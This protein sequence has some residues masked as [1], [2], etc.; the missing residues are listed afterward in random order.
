MDSPMPRARTYT[1]HI[2]MAPANTKAAR[3]AMSI[4]FTAR[5]FSSTLRGDMRSTT[6]PPTSTNTASGRAMSASTNPSCCGSPVSFSTSQGRANNVNWSPRI[7]IELPMNSRR[8]SRLANSEV[9]EFSMV[10]Y[11]AAYRWPH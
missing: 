8:K 11:R 10:C 5:E 4:A 3:M 6:A 9:L 1:S 7:E 2:W